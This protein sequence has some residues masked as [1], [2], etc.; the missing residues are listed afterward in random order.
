[1]ADKAIAKHMLMLA[2]EPFKVSSYKALRKI[3]MDTHQYDK[4]W[5]ISNTLAFLKQADPEEQQ[6]Y[7]QYRPRGFVKAQQRMTDEIWK[8]VYH[9]DEDRFIDAIFSV[10]YQPIALRQARTHK[11]FGLKRKDK[12]AIEN[13]QLVFSK[14]LYYA[15]QVLNMQP[16]EVYLQQD[17]PGE[18]LLANCHEKGTLIPSLVVRAQLLGGRAEKE[19]AFVCGRQLCYM[20]AEHYLKPVL[21]TNH[22]L[23]LAFLAAVKL[24]YPQL[25]LSKDLDAPVTQAAQQL[26]ANL[27]PQ[28]KEQL[29]F[30]V[31][32]FIE[33]KGDIDLSKWSA[34][35]DSTAHRVGFVLC[36]DLE[37]AARMVST[38]PP[39][40]G[41]PTAKEKVKE[42]I[43][44]SISE[45]YFTVRNHLGVTIRLDG[46]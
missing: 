14:V 24:G 42:L 19:I 33:R 45:D 10:I 31:R 2:D 17:Q 27:P 6:F 43:L 29:I 34:A 1:M 46:Q 28:W 9:P 15:C 11:D 5:C 35:V 39:A 21:V 13:D 23:K 22:D 18:I 38:E 25:P 7:E 37:V 36:G 26:F 32:Q 40:V 16:P 3:Y 12:R 30:V 4:A 44:Y 41:A 20:R 8:R